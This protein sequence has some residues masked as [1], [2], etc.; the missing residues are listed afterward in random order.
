M[1]KFI[2]VVTT[3]DSQAVAQE[4]A[5]A[6]VEQKVAACVQISQCQSTYRWQGAIKT[7]SEFLCVMKSRSDLFRDVE[8]IVKK[9][10]PYDVP[11]IIATE[12]VSGSNE[13]LDWLNSELRQGGEE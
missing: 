10:H 5:R 12:I 8:E 2:Q 13:Y 4:I 1:T 3:V 7:A 9:I 6:V 11:E